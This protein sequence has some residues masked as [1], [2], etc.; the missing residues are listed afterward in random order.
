[1]LKSTPTKKSPATKAPSPLKVNAKGEITSWS[2]NSK[3]DELLK[4][5]FEKG[6][7]EKPTATSIKKAFPQ[8]A[9]YNTKT[10]NSPFQNIRKALESE[11]NAQRSR[12]PMCKNGNL[13]IFLFDDISLTN[14]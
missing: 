3:D 9:R 8:F 6:I 1:M 14:F 13:L 11:V 12:V 10:L 2:G 5:I 4:V 7:V